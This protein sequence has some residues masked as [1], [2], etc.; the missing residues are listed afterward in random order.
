LLAASPAVEDLAAAEARH[1]V[2]LSAR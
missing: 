1:V 2:E